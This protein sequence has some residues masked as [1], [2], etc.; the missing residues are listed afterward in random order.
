[1]P[2]THN[3]VPIERLHDFCA[4]SHAT[5]C[6]L[7]AHTVA[8]CRWKNSP[9]SNKVLVG[10]WEVILGVPL[11]PWSSSTCTTIQAQR[12][13]SSPSSAHEEHAVQLTLHLVVA[14][15]HFFC[16]TSVRGLTCFAKKSMSW[17]TAMVAMAM[18][19]PVKK[20]LPF[21]LTLKLCTSQFS[22]RGATR[23]SRSVLFS[24]KLGVAL[25]RVRGQTHPL[26]TAVAGVPS[27]QGGS[28]ASMMGG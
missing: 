15:P 27:V 17:L 12:V 20:A 13:R 14:F 26:S 8:C 22:V 4:R 21:M 24:L 19:T 6:L 1:M 11:L 2:C 18:A 3:G 16:T 7:T 5:N 28:R 10:A 9:K 25:G 23:L